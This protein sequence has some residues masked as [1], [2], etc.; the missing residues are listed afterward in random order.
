M[1]DLKKVYKAPTKSAAEDALL[2]L[3]QKW[4][5]KYPMVINSWTNNWTELSAYFLTENDCFATASLH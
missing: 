1:Q 2:E 4:G 3:E 5:E